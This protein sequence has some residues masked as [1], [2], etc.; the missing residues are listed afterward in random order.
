MKGEKDV[1]K[2]EVNVVIIQADN[3]EGMTIKKDLMRIV[4]NPVNAVI[5]K[6]LYHL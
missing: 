5:P 6:V 3:P 4:F 2:E 1:K